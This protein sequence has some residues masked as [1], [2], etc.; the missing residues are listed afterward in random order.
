MI[1]KNLRRRSNNIFFFFF[2][3]LHLP[4]P[5]LKHHSTLLLPT[6]KIPTLNT[7]VIVIVVVVVVVVHRRARGRATRTR[8][9]ILTSK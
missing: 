9:P 6:P 5:T 8:R 7:P 2:F 4:L 1:K 3:F